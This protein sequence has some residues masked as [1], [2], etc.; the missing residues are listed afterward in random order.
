MRILAL[1]LAP[2]TVLAIPVVREFRRPLAL[3]TPLAT[4][5]LSLASSSES[6]ESLFEPLLQVPEATYTVPTV[7]VVRV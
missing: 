3:A 1:P 4:A 6:L 2:V 7:I 5:M